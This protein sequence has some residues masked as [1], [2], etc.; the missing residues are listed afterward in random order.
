ML[1]VNDLDETLNPRFLRRLLGR[2]L[3]DDLAR[4]LLESGHEAVSV[5]TLTV[6]VV[7][8]T[9]DH[10]FLSGVSALKKDH[11]L[12]LL[13][14][15]HHCFFS[16]SP[17]S[18]EF[19]ENSW[20]NSEESGV[21][22]IAKRTCISSKIYSSSKSNSM[23]IFS[24]SSDSKSDSS[25]SLI[26]S[27]LDELS[28]SSEEEVGPL[29]PLAIS[30]AAGFSGAI[31]AAA[32]HSFDTARTRAQCVILPKFGFCWIDKDG[33]NLCCIQCYR[34]M[35]LLSCRFIGSKVKNN[36]HHTLSA[37]L[38]C[39]DQTYQLCYFVV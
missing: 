19:S 32:S 33:S 14:E 25:N 11:C 9:D 29:S 6:S 24:S 13:Q 22:E 27:S 1:V 28:F 31:A 35:L 12:V 5:R 34:W 15:L 23:S 10:G 2:V 38:S 8:G 20:F 18:G 16:L 37:N 21:Q 7:E 39:I 3:A 4:V 36:R 26:K 30:I 17:L